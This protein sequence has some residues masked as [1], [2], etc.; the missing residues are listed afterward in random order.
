MTVLS[1]A[2]GTPLTSQVLR[3]R[4]VGYGDEP[5]ASHQMFLRDLKALKSIGVFVKKSHEAGETLY[6]LAPATFLPE[7]EF[8]PEEAYVLQL[9][10]D[11]SAYHALGSSAHRGWSKLVAFAADRD[12]E[13][14]IPF[15]THTELWEVP[16]DVVSG[17]LNAIRKEQAVCLTYRR[18][19]LAS[20][21]TR[22]LEP[23]G[24][25]SHNERQYVVGFDLDREATRSFRLLRITAVES[26]GQ[27]THPR[28]KDFRAAAAQALQSFHPTVTATVTHVEDAAQA[29]LRTGQRVDATTV[30]FENVDR[31]W[32]IRNALSYCESVTVVEPAEVRDEVVARLRQIV[33][34]YEGSN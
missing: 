9:A 28:P 1:N 15:F 33:S 22:R 23:W 24:I 14:G 19:K 34:S 4:T 27:S 16:T 11:V 30:R 17:L 10:G 21:E 31:E 20:P 32:L 18:D 12:R 13:P 26:A 3:S 2:H 6:S 8:T 25:V 7:E 5:K 29:F